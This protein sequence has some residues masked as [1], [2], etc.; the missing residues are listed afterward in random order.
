M[1]DGPEPDRGN[2]VPIARNSLGTLGEAEALYAYC[3][4]CKRSERLDAAALL[5]RHGDLPLRALRRRLR[6]T[7]CGRSDAEVVRATRSPG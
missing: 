5:G 6:C 2:V 4:V 7:A 1:S 3:R